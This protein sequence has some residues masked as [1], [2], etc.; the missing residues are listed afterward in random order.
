MA[1]KQARIVWS[2]STSHRD[3]SDLLVIAAI[4][5]EGIESEVNFC[6]ADQDVCRWLLNS[7]IVQKVNEC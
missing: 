1:N 7:A 2:K 3:T 4:E 5:A 6:D